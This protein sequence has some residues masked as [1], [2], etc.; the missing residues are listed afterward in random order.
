MI[1]FRQRL[2]PLFGGF[3]AVLTLQASAGVLNIKGE[4]IHSVQGETRGTLLELSR[5]RFSGEF[6]D[7][8]EWQMSMLPTSTG[9]RCS[10]WR[11]GEF[12]YFK[13]ELT[14]SPES[15]AVNVGIISLMKG[16]VPKFN[17][18]QEL[19][20]LW[21]LFGGNKVPRGT[22]GSTGSVKLLVD[23]ECPEFGH[24]DFSF[25]GRCDFN[26]TSNSFGP[27]YYLLVNDGL[28]RCWANYLDS[29]SVPPDAVE[30]KGVFRKGFTNQ[31]FEVLRSSKETSTG[32]LKYSIP[33]YSELKVVYPDGA[34]ETDLR[35]VFVQNAT[36]I[37]VTNYSYEPARTLSVSQQPKLEGI[38]LF[39]DRRL[40]TQDDEM[41]VPT[42]TYVTNRWLT[43]GELKEL[44]EY[45][46]TFVVANQR[47]KL[48]YEE[49]P[50]LAPV[51]IRRG[52]F[53]S[54]LVVASL[55]AL[56]TVYKLRGR[57]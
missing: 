21:L 37:T 45:S 19:T 13:E 43:V 40:T 38:Y 7:T 17:N 1:L 24:S 53:V 26:P 8:G 56:A 46:S 29:V 15:Q 50:E 54:A 18:H 3:L 57:V 42:I 36:S 51:R 4:L 11:D 10:A 30:L 9:S 41:A 48:H 55:V 49:H 2:C 35:S 44:P 47:R 32:N 52:L 27:S 25:P 6:S 12:I 39:A 34:S 5:T 14:K 23:Y 31:V 22:I 16:P 20:W 28:Q 33:V